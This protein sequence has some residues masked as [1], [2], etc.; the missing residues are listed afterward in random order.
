MPSQSASSKSSPRSWV[1]N[2]T[3]KGQVRCTPL[4]LLTAYTLT[5][6]CS[7]SQER[8]GAW[9]P[10]FKRSVSTDLIRQRAVEKE[11]SYE[12]SQ[13]AK[14]GT[15]KR[16]Q[17]TFSVDQPTTSTPN[18]TVPKPDLRP[19]AEFKETSTRCGRQT[20]RTY[21]AGDEFHI[22]TDASAGSRKRKHLPVDQPFLQFSSIFSSDFGPSTLSAQLS[23]SSAMDYGEDISNTS[24]RGFSI[25][26]PTIELPLDE[27]LSNVDPTDEGLSRHA[28]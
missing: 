18:T 3:K 1:A 7:L 14:P 21:A 16:M 11:H 9:A 13:N 25:L 15:T 23:H 26:R 5:L 6:F 8:R 2:S 27:I 19:S 24:S 22:D 28:N 12:A 4:F 10:D 17:F 20:T